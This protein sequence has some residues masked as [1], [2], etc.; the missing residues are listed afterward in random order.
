MFKLFVTSLHATITSI[1]L[2]ILMLNVAVK[3]PSDL[4]EK[5]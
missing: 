3:F 5:S 4:L 2:T 1:S